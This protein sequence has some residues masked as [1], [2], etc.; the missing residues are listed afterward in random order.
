[1]L[2]A[3]HLNDDVLERYAMR[4]LSETEAETIE[5]HL[6]LCSHCLDR[7]DETT[8]YVEGCGVH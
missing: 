3:G 1:M 8:A 5:E 2:I 7:L 6:A 4:S